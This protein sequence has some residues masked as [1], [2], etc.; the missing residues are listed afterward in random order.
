M[1]TNRK[2]LA[3]TSKTPGKTAEFNYFELRSRYNDLVDAFDG[4]TGAGNA[5]RG[6]T[7]IGVHNNNVGSGDTFGVNI[8]Q[9]E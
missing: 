5:I 9:K 7:V 6:A 8:T 4:V 3:Y 2:G 1:M